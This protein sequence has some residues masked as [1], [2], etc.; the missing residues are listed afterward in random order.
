MLTTM[1]N[2]NKPWFLILF[3]LLLSIAQLLITL[4]TSVDRLKF[5]TCAQTGFCSH[6]RPLTTTST[7]VTEK[8]FLGPFQEFSVASTNNKNPSILTS[9]SINNPKISATLTCLFSG[10]VRLTVKD[11][12]GKPRYDSSQDI[13]VDLTEKPWILSNNQ[14][15]TCQGDLMKTNLILTTSPSLKIEVRNDE[16]GLPMMIFGDRGL[17]H[18]ESNQVKAN[19]QQQQQQQQQIPLSD[20]TTTTTTVVETTPKE[21][22]IRDWGE[23]GKPIY[24]DES[25]TDNTDDEETKP[26]TTTTPTTDRSAPETFGGVTDNKKNG[27]QSIGFDITFSSPYPQPSQP[28]F[29]YG[30]PEHATSF[31]LKD[32][33]G[34]DTTNKKTYSEPYRLYNLDVF[35]YELD[36]P[37]ALYGAIPILLSRSTNNKKPSS[38]TICGIYFNNPTETFVDVSTSHNN[39]QRQTHWMSEAGYLDV[40]IYSGSSS[41]GPIM[42]AHTRITGRPQL[43]PLFAL[44]YHQCRWNYRDQRD[45]EEIHAKFE[46]ID[47]PVDVIWLDIE[48]TDGKKYFTWD[49]SKF[50]DPVKMMKDLNHY[51]RKLVTIVDPHVKRESGYWVHDEATALGMY[52]KEEDKDYDGWCWPGSS[53]YPD[54]TSAK[55]RTW[56]GNYYLHNQYLGENHHIWNDMNEPSV[57]NGPE[58]TMKKSL[59][60]L[61]GYEHREWHN[62][63]GYFYHRA[64]FE[65]MIMARPNIRPFVLTRSVFAG[66]QTLGAIWTGDNLASYDHMK[67]TIPMIL[68]L[69]VGGFPFAGA[70]APGFFKDPSPELL[71][72]WYQV[73]SY[74]PFFR[75]HAHIDTKR[76]EP[77]LFGDE[78]LANVR[79]AVMNRYKILPYIYTLFEEAHRTGMP[80]MRPLWWSNAGEVVSNEDRAWLLGGDL[81]IYPVLDE[82]AT[83][84]EINLP[85][86]FWYDVFSGGIK[87]EHIGGASGTPMSGPITVH[88]PLGV[89]PV[90]QRAGSIVPKR[91]RLRRS[92]SLMIHDPYTLTVALGSSSGSGN[93]MIASGRLFVDDFITIHSKGFEV[94]FEAQQHQQQQQFTI[95]G[96]VSSTSAVVMTAD[97]N[98]LTHKIERI[99]VMGIRCP[100]NGVVDGGIAIQ[101][102]KQWTFDIECLENTNNVMI[103]RKPWVNV[104]MDFELKVGGGGGGSSGSGN[105]A[106]KM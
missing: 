6:Y 1:N 85:S 43:P 14:V 96:K 84:V 26:T 25:T 23:D 50:P 44:A 12:S 28:P 17:L 51:G 67:A 20:T 4:V 3:V 97:H 66:S 72:R 57:F 47:F 103:L 86:G 64:T 10:S 76:R 60:N 16:T 87:T 48:H 15:V 27:P 30:L 49:K 8:A 77:W 2:N 58:V 105:V 104:N 41:L 69:G 102:G 56:W 40:F 94:K 21:R 38:G 5:R 54:F 7:M 61:N 83:Y 55:V 59:L 88:A 24:E 89:L 62:V 95:T 65:G 29:L 79:R 78:V 22:K 75:A 82:G 63:Y 99:V 71:T 80:V 39:N 34:S 106:S 98:D 32:T 19:D 33:D 68:S 74:Q 18:Y 52:V 70:D 35:E 92:A 31:A 101:N 45:V 93:T 13:L 100:T 90:F 91:L 42:N 37:M 73:A 53:S 36:E 9:T 46:E 81:F 11:E